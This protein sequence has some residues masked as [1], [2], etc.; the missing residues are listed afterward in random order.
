MTGYYLAMCVL[1]CYVYIYSFMFV[2]EQ[3]VGYPGTYPE[4]KSRE[5]VG[6][7]FRMVFH[8]AIQHYNMTS[9]KF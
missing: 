3:L 9:I 7:S 4:I 6:L 8:I 1:C 5:V 2:S